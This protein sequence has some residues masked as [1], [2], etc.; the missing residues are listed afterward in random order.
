MLKAWFCC[1]LL[2][3]M[4]ACDFGPGRRTLPEIVYIDPEFFAG[5]PIQFIKVLF[6]AVIDEPNLDSTGLSATLYISN[7][8][9]ADLEPI[10]GIDESSVARTFEW[11]T[12]NACRDLPQ[13][14]SL[15]VRYEMYDAAG[16]IIQANGI[17][18][19]I[20]TCR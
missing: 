18:A 11:F 9:S 19:D 17:I 15:R 1:A 10:S 14:Q 12:D 6:V 13:G 7:S 2:M 3:V 20:D 8:F 5:E 16:D 4:T